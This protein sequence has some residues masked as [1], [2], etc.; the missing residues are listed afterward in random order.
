M[1]RTV[2]VVFMLFAPAAFTAPAPAFPLAAVRPP[3]AATPAPDP[4]EA[5]LVGL[6]RRSWQAWQQRDGAFFE[7]FLSDDH[8]EVGIQGIARKRSVVAGVASPACV[9]RGYTLDAFQFT[10]LGPTTAVLMYHAEQDTLC[11]GQR[12][13]SP[14]WV[15]SLYVLRG[16]RWQNA[17]YQQTPTPASAQSPKGGH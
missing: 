13:P 16:G 15:S 4:L 5:T 10:R 17:V 14:A 3:H 7:K 11:G 1:I 12:V 6:E 9:V 8:V 2:L